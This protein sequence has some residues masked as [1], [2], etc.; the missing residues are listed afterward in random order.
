MLLRTVTALVGLAILFT[1]L[2][3]GLPG[4]FFITLL[5]AVLG[6]REFYRLHP[7]DSSLSAPDNSPPAPGI[8]TSLP[9]TEVSIPDTSVL[10]LV[11]DTATDEDLSQA[12][13][14]PTHIAGDPS[15]I[16]ANPSQTAANPLQTIA[17]GEPVEPTPQNSATNTGVPEQPAITSQQSCDTTTV[18]PASAASLDYDCGEAGKYSSEEQPVSPAPDAPA[19]TSL[20]NLVGAVWVAAFVIGGAAANSLLHFWGVSLGVFLAGGFIALLW[21][22]A[23]YHGP[24]WPVAAVY[25]YGGPLYVGFLLAHVLALAQVGENF[26]YANP[27]AFDFLSFPDDSYSLGR[28]WVLFALLT[29]FATDTGA[30]LVGRAIGRHPMAPGISPNKTWEG[31]VGGFIGAIIA[32]LLLERLLNLGLGTPGLTGDLSGVWSQ[33][34]NW[35]PLLI[36][37]TVG[38]VAQLGDL[39]ESKL[40]RLSQVKDAGGLMPGHGGLLDRLDSLLI[41][42]PVVYYLL[43][44]VLR[45]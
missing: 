5:A 10:E 36:G 39:L 22:I 3:G 31:A 43:V 28:N 24:R 4:V 12:T 13:A 35:Q 44:A 45:P 6:I 34:W 41:T 2:W 11:D 37:A 27:T 30:Y 16:T 26:F 15:R 40:K 29:T 14:Q 19:A 17:H 20:P 32:A 7:P 25:L 8:D 23:F 38:I 21:F 33:A 1:C 18:A 42:I 9:T